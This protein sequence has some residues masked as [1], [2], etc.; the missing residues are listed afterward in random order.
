MSHKKVQ[1]AL[2]SHLN[3]YQKNIVD[4]EYKFKTIQFWNPGVLLG[5]LPED[6]LKRL[7]IDCK[8]LGAELNATNYE[9]TSKNLVGYIK[10]QYMYPIQK[11][12][13]LVRY[14]LNMAQSWTEEFKYKFH[15]PKKSISFKIEDVWFNLQKEGEYNPN[16]HHSGDLSFVI[17]IQIPY[18]VQ[19]QL[20]KDK[21]WINEETSPK[22]AFEFL[23]STMC[24]GIHYHRIWVDHADV[25]SIIMFPSKLQHC[26]YPFSD[27]DGTRISMSGNIKVI[28][29]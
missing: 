11:N 14:L 1:D 4:R 5:K 7:L 3:D 13:N 9:S 22:T 26:V 17:W 29:E 19:E 21:W 28:A 18:F 10:E 8:D 23:Y 2:L 6:I 12:S 15:N 27:C 16:H 20:S 25:G 24:L